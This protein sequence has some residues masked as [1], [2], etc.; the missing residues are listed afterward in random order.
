MRV[1][2]PQVILSGLLLWALYPGNPY[3]YYTL[4]RWVACGVFL[5]LAYLAFESKRTVWLWVLGI[6]AV[7]YNPIIRIHLTREIW[8]VLNV[9]SIVILVVSIFFIERIEAG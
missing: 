5:Y 8:N 9:I 4:L 1:W 3:G 2:I 6:N 7:I